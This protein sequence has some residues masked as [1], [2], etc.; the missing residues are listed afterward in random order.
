MVIDSSWSMG[1]ETANGDTRWERAMAQARTL[2]AASAG[3][4]VALATTADGLVEGPTTDSVLLEAALDRIAPAGGEQADWPQLS[5]V[6]VRALHYG[7]NAAASDRRSRG[8]RRQ[9]H[10]A[11][12]V[13]A[14]VEP[15]HHGV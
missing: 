13:R 8:G 5:G 14:C 3:D 6:S 7:R 1:T 15:G 2:I 11:V 10:R 9:G 4:E 12:R